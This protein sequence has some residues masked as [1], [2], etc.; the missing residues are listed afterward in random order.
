VL[1]RDSWLPLLASRAPRLASRLER[2]LH[3]E[4]NWRQRAGSLWSYRRLRVLA[5]QSFVV[6]DYSTRV[7][8]SPELRA[9]FAPDGMSLPPL[10][11]EWLKPLLPT[12]IWILQ[13][14]A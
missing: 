9:L 8:S 14:Q 13:K 7:L 6:H 5:S 1:A 12:H 3:A 4:R 2:P 10:A 11:V